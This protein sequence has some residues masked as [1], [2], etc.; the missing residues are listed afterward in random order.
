MKHLQYQRFSKNK[1]IKKKVITY[2]SI[3]LDNVL[4]TS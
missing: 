3:N 1:V 2:V 4:E